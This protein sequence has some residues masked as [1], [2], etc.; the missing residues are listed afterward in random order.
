MEV[1]VNIERMDNIVE[2]TLE[3]QEPVIQVEVIGSGP[4]GPRGPQGADGAQ[5]E[6][7]EKGDTGATGATGPAGPAGPGVPSGG[8]TGQFLKKAS[9]TDYDGAWASIGAA[10]VGA[11][12]A[13]ASPSDGQF[14]VYSQAQSAW[15][16][17]TVP[18]ANG[19]SF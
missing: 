18:S 11:V 5:G 16:A 7:G 1:N 8:T 14:L 15:V 9:A 19:V 17:Q 4:V 6:K 3:N 2:V 12:A 13:P 10:D